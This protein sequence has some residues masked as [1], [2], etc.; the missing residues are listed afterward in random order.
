MAAEQ[1]SRAT[2]EVTV[3]PIA[4]LPG[5]EAKSLSATI[6][7]ALTPS[8]LLSQN[9][10]ALIQL[11]IQSVTPTTSHRLP[12]TLIASLINASTLALLN[13]GSVPM[14]GVVCAVAVGR[15]QYISANGP[16][17]IALVLDPSD[18][19]LSSVRGGG[20]F[21]FLFAADLKEQQAKADSGSRMQCE[22]VWSHWHA[23]T[24][25]DD[26]ELG[27]ARELANAGAEQ[28]WCKMKESVD[29]MNAPSQ[30]ISCFS[31]KK[32]PFN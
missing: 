2:F 28:V 20:C 21:A 24:A 17:A 10:R 25:F 12:Y 6:R 14:R 27:R 13:S 5:T 1:A 32:T 16:N 8:L 26:N 15:L 11:V 4:G 7:A 29:W 23:T 3:R 9:P 18:D 31:K 22:V 19:E 30:G